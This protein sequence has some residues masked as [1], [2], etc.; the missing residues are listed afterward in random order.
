MLNMERIFFRKLRELW[1]ISTELPRYFLERTRLHVY[2]ASMVSNEVE[3]PETYIAHDMAVRSLSI[4][5]LN[6]STAKFRD[7]E[8]R[9]GVDLEGVQIVNYTQQQPKEVTLLSD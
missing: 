9:V 4:S 6:E 3:N 5:Q 1:T 7:E 2:L 8:T